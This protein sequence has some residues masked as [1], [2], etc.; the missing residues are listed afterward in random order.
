MPVEPTPI[1]ELPT[2]PSRDMARLTFVTTINAWYAGWPAWRTAANALA[3][4]TYS[5]AVEAAE[6]AAAAVA[7]KVAAEVAATAAETF[8]SAVASATDYIGTSTTQVTVGAGSQAFTT[9]AGLAIA[10]SG[11]RVT[12]MSRG[13][14]AKMRGVATYS[15][16][17][18][19]ITVDDVEGS[20]E[21]SDWLLVL[22][23]LEPVTLA[24]ATATAIAFAIAL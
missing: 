24:R 16:T 15:G 14:T 18:L 1:P 23:A 19:T 11:D 22:S 9:Q 10:A 5:N 4:A 21:H 13:S 8:A 12:A 3:Q 17:T 2:S 7:A 6:S 20:G